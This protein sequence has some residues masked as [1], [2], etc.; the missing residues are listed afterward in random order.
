[1]WEMATPGPPAADTARTTQLAARKQSVKEADTLLVVGDHLRNPA[2]NLVKQIFSNVLKEKVLQV[3]IRDAPAGQSKLPGAKK[4]ERTVMSQDSCL[5]TE[6]DLP[7]CSLTEMLLEGA[8]VIDH[9]AAWCPDTPGW[10]TL[11]PL[12]NTAKRV[13][14]LSPSYYPEV[15]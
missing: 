11:L 10:D 14:W 5:V 6:C 1:M 8:A 13:P 2:K 12:T 9:L 4:A 3:L 15:F 7:A